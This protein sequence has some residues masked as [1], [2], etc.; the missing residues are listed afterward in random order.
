MHERLHPLVLFLGS[1]GLLGGA[2]L[3]QYVGNLPPCPL[4]LWQRYPH[5]AVLVLAAAALAIARPRFQAACLTLI[6]LA[7]VAGAAIAGFHVG[8]EQGWW[9]GTAACQAVP[10]LD[11]MD[12][13]RLRELAIGWPAAR[14]DEVPWSLFGVSMA[15]WNLILSLLLTVIAV[16]GVFRCR[17]RRR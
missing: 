14:C 2:L 17:R 1:A 5:A 6:A 15:G 12:P 11:T 8:V 10:G 9:A 16:D 4:C 3:F 7:L 13:A